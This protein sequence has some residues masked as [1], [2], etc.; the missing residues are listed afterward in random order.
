MNTA[1]Q[2]VVGNP[3]VTYR[4]PTGEHISRISNEMHQ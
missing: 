1:T 2:V 3:G 4:R